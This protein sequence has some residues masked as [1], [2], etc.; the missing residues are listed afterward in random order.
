VLYRLYLPGDFAQLYAIEE[1][2]FQPPFRF[3]RAYMRQLL[4]RSGTAAWIAEEGGRMAGFAMIE[5]TRKAARTVAYIQTI[6]VLPELRGKG[7]GAVLLRRVE[8]S[9][10]AAGAQTIWLHVDAENAAA[11]RLY[12]AN[13]Y[14]YKGREE[15][16]YA[17]GRPALI[18][19]MPL[20][21]EQRGQPGK[22]LAEEKGD[23]I[24]P[25]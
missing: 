21:A 11:I 23:A 17:M 3:D 18:Y 13:G 5:W 14:E 4:D 7:V 15:D 12:Q 1:I 10:R 22:R 25:E 9:A 20:K 16:Y 19:S 2:C 8:A 24:G 6:E